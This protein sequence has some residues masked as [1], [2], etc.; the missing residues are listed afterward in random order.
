MFWKRRIEPLTAPF[1]LRLLN[2]MTHPVPEAVV[3]VTRVTRGAPAGSTG[4][5]SVAW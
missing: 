4:F 5:T 1:K 3:V 2:G